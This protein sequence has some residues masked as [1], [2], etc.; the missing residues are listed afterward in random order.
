MC[1]KIYANRQTAF[2]IVRRLEK[3]PSLSYRLGCVTQSSFVGFLY[4]SVPLGISISV[5]KFG[6][7]KKAQ[8]GLDPAAI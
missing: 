2:C 7:I 4:K 3:G 8:A 6:Q 1:A 5:K